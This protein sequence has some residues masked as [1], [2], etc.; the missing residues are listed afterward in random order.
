MKLISKA[1]LLAGVVTLTACH[2]DNDDEIRL[3]YHGVE[4]TIKNLDNW[5]KYAS[6]VARLLE[7]DAADL[8]HSWETS[9]EG[10]QPFADIF[11][12]HTT[13]YTSA[14]A[15][16]EQ[17][18][19]GCAEIANEVG[20]AKIGD[21]LELL[22][23]GKTQEALFAVESWFSW[24]S[25]EDYA[26]N[27]LS[28]RNS[29]YGTLDGSISPASMSALVAATDPTLDSTVKQQI[30]LAEAAIMAIPDPFRNNINSPETRTAMAAC[31]NLEST[32]NNQL[33]PFFLNLKGQDEK[34]Q[35]IVENYVDAVVLPTYRALAAKTAELYKAVQAMTDAPSN[36]TFAAAAEA[37]FAARV[38]WE[39]SEAFLFGPVDALGLDPNMDSWPLDQTAISNHIT[40]GD[41]SSLEWSDGDSDQAIEN[42]QNVRG[43]HTLE[44]LLFLDGK[45]RTVDSLK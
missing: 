20:T 17:I 25:R 12:H 29:Y 33:K 18:I 38:P 10:G 30:A 40:N 15:C 32:L 44:F 27:I 28:I 4:L 6:Q 26:N 31:A 37:W 11:K 2:D 41:F 14:S 7:K 1:L 16:I 3:D 21:P 35:L 45:P 13:T 8:L 43:F 19:D 5:T 39:Q 23:N 24:H 34:E 9:Y 22:L 42:A 36:Q